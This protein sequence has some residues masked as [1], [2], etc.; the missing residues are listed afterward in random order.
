MTMQIPGQQGATG[1]RTNECGQESV[2]HA[3]M[4][5]RATRVVT[6]VTAIVFLIGTDA[7]AAQRAS[8]SLNPDISAIGDIFFDLS[9]KRPRFTE[10]GT[11]FALAEVELGIQAFVDP[12][13]RA[14][15]F[16]GL[17]GG[18]IEVEEGYVTA[19]ALPG[20]LQAKLGRLHLPFGKVNL[21]H[22]PELLT[23][24]YPHVHQQYFSGEGF[25]STGLG[26]SRIFAPL[27][28]Y[29][30]LQFY[31]LS[32]LGADEH[33]HEEEGEGHEEEAPLPDDVSIVE[34]ERAGIE[35]FAFL[36]HLRTY[37]D[38]SP[39][40][41]IEFGVSAATGHVER[42]REPFCTTGAPCAALE[43]TFRT[44]RFIGVNAIV[45]W[46]PPAQGR[47][48]SFQWSAEVVGNDG[49]EST[50]WGWFSGNWDDGATWRRESMACRLPV[51]SMSHTC[52]AVPTRS[53]SKRKR[54]ATG[55]A[56]RPDT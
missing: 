35:Q 9:P 8:Q 14:D 39:S 54:V 24:E 5:W 6:T 36:A 42:L 40:T 20:E 1:S 11:R 27:G 41:N 15:F 26:L 37:A 7:L 48:R 16:L 25:R 4:R 18:E 3:S 31:V 45:R 49:P 43:S 30:E 55:S 51:S 47:Y 10:D 34:N 46:R 19:L 53:Y 33:A 13:F 29:Q 52:R 22:R 44:Q 50:V 17:H 32:G 12:F 38:L 2:W 28:V 23:V 21:T 56:P